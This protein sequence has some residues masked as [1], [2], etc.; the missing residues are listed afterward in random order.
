M[1]S[2]ETLSTVVMTWTHPFPS[3]ASECIEVECC[4][5]LSSLLNFLF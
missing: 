2:F 3:W 4:E 1:I 5:S